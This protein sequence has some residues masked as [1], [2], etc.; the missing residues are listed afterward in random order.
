MAAEG[1]ASI[2]GAVEQTNALRDIIE[3]LA[4]SV[5]GLGTRSKEIGR[6]VDV[7]R[8][9]ASQTD[10]LALNAAIEA[11]RAGEYG[12]GFAVVADEVRQ[13]AEQSADAAK[14]ITQLVAE[15]KSGKGDKSM[16]QGAAGAARCGSGAGERRP[17][18]EI[19]EAVNGLPQIQE[20][21]PVDRLP[22]AVSNV[23]PP[24]AINF[25]SRGGTIGTETDGDSQELEAVERIIRL[26]SETMG[27][28]RW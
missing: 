1:D 11:A 9:I 24:R 6:I 14:D 26:G 7:I 17:D 12:R 25:H 23:L 16:N 20:V 4:D 10:L 13:L 8:D 28:Q 2:V 15:I 27:C 21:V 3:G 18:A 5:E 22:A 19:L